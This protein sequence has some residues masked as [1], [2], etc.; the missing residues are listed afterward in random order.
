MSIELKDKAIHLAYY[1][2]DRGFKNSYET[3]KEVK[4]KAGG[5]THTYV[6]GWFARNV[7]RT[8]KEGTGSNSFVAPHAKYECEVDLFFY[9]GC[10]VFKA[11]VSI[12]FFMY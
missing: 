12:W 8:T 10:T 9:N 7:E 1:N 2:I 4:S 5:I 3:W 11:G 6:K